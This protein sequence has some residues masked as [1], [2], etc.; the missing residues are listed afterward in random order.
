[1]KRITIFI[2]LFALIFSLGVFAETITLTW[3]FED[4]T[5][6]THETSGIFSESW[7]YKFRNPNEDVNKVIDKDGNKV[8]EVGALT[9]LVYKDKL[10]DPYTLS[11][12]LQMGRL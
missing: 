1:M 12:R 9:Q 10:E 5:G 7:L 2:L 6:D 8:Y 4:A 3:D 11:Y